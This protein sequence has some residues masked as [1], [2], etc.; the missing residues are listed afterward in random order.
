M[1]SY[2]YIK[3]SFVFHEGLLKVRIN[4][5]SKVQIRNIFHFFWKDGFVKS[6]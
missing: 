6:V 3:M 4:S 1:L 5:G 2:P